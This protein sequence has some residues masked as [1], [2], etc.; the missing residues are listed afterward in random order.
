M[1]SKGNKIDVRG[2]NRRDFIKYS[3]AVGA[4]LGLDRW[5]VF[6]VTESSAGKAQISDCEAS[7]RI[8]RSKL[9]RV[10]GNCS[11]TRHVGIIQHGTAS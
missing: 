5:K 2:A 6:E 8:T 9:A 1:S 7:S 10:A 4:L 11:E 3:V